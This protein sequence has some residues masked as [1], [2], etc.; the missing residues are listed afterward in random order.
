MNTNR[1]D[2]LKREALMDNRSQTLKAL[3]KILDEYPSHND[4]MIRESLISQLLALYTNRLSQIRAV[5]YDPMDV[6]DCTYM[7]AS[8]PIPA[9]PVT[10]NQKKSCTLKIR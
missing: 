5:R 7:G 3:W 4:V 9:T 2:K 8:Y 1:L 6:F 10:N